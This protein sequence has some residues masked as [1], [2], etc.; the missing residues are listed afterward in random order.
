VSARLTPARESPRTGIKSF[1][2]TFFKKVTA[3]SLSFF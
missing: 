3:F 2:V 1:L